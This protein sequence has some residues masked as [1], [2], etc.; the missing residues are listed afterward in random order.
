MVVCGGCG[1]GVRACCDC[2][3]VL[4]DMRV[5]WECEGVLGVGG[6]VGAMRLGGNV[7][8]TDVR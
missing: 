3:G 6:C 1:V 8:W 5:C 2:D 7:F 4:E